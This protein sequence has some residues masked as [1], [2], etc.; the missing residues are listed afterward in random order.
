MTHK[1]VL[2]Q[3]IYQQPDV[4]AQLL[5]SADDAVRDAAARISAFEPEFVLMAARGS[6]DNAA[7]YA[8]YVFGA[9]NELPVALAAPSLFTLYRRPPRLKRALTIG[10]SQSGQSPDVVAVIEET[11][12]QGGLTLAITNDPAS[13]LAV[14]ASSC[15]GLGVTPEHSIAATKTYTATLLALAMLSTELD[16]EPARAEAL[17]RVPDAVRD[18]LACQPLLADGAGSF[19]GYSRFL[20][21]GR[22]FNY[23]TTFEIALKMKE[24]SYVHAEAHSVADLMHGPLA[25]VDDQLPVLMVAPSGEGSDEALLLLLRLKQLGAPIIAFSDR[26]SLLE[27]VDLGV[28]LVRVPEW[29]SPIVAIVPGQ[30]WALELAVA[31]GC[32]A[33]HPRGLT[34]I[35]RTQ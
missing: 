17:R 26:R 29:L 35:T 19:A 16:G 8:Q 6:S 18:A 10:L 27:R 23:S 5:T 33:D 25:M 2:S 24:T 4:L 31:R 22:G 32:D 11:R 9:F 7:R 21:V 15:I 30:L 14:A 20:V 1:S 28:P 34:K 12:R 13:P 3:E